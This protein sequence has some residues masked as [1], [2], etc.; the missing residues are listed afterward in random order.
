[1]STREKS[2]FF[3]NF[4]VSKI[5]GILSKTLSV[6]CINKLVI[7]LATPIFPASKSTIVIPRPGV[8]SIIFNGRSNLSFFVI[9]DIISLLSQIWFPV[10][11]TSAPTRKKSS[12][13]EGVTPNPPAE[14]ST[15]TIIASNFNFVLSSIIFS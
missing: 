14:F 13:I 3:F 5:S 1:M 6:F 9:Y 11:N 2:T 15:L 4:K 10:V 7:I 12:Q 8:P